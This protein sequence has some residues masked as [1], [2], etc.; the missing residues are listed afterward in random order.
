MAYL[1]A[2]RSIKVAPGFKVNLNKRNG[3]DA[4]RALLGQQLG[5]ARTSTVGVPGT[6]LSLSTTRAAVEPAGQPPR[7]QRDLPARSGPPPRRRSA[8]RVCLL[9][10]TSGPTRRR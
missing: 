8:T 9:P 6:G 1:R 3:G 10:T 5:P 4:R 2:Q 7:T